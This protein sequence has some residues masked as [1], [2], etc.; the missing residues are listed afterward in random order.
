[1]QTTEPTTKPTMAGK[2]A[3]YRRHLFAHVPLYTTR[4]VKEGDFAFSDRGQVNTPEAVAVVLQDFFDGKDREEFVVVL[5]DTA[6]TMIGISVLSVGGLAASIVEPRQVMKVAVLANAASIIC[7]HNH[8]SGNPEPSC[9][10]LRVTRQL[11]EAGELMSIPLLDHLI[12]T[13]DGYTSMAERN[14]LR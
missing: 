5:L 4:L 1:M 6:N 13:G 9:A 8:V 3:D 2:S 7:A 10:D 12:I 11:T 14:L